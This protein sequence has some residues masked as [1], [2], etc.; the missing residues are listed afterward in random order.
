MPGPPDCKVP[1]PAHLLRAQ[2]L[3]P[4]WAQI[5]LLHEIEKWGEVPSSL[6]WLGPPRG[7]WELEPCS[8]CT[9]LKYL[10]AQEGQDGGEKEHL[11]LASWLPPPHLPLPTPTLSQQPRWGR[12]LFAATSLL[13]PQ[14][15]SR[16]ILFLPEEQPRQCWVP[17][18]GHWD[19]IHAPR[20]L[21]QWLSKTY[22]PRG[23]LSA[24]CPA[25][26]G[27]EEGTAMEKKAQ[28]L[29]ALRLPLAWEP[30]IALLPSLPRELRLALLG[31][32]YEME[33]AIGMWGQTGRETSGQDSAQPC[34]LC[35]LP[36]LSVPSNECSL[37]LCVPQGRWRP[38][39][40]GRGPRPWPGSC[41]ESCT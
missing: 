5:P 25:L 21:I 16:V 10:Y 32:V 19:W 31:T 40:P 14:E 7:V 13:I 27:W 38:G 17:K 37:E 29:S 15:Y 23:P 41:T 12:L 6:I 30:G 24:E 2:D 11:V 22:F 28:S 4:L 1:G 35:S 3:H 20:S 18:N 33:G 39:V 36:P 8:P 9:G 34:L 26:C